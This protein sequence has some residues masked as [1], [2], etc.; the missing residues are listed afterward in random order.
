M[1]KVKTYEE[2]IRIIL[3]NRLE[4]NCNYNIEKRNVIVWLLCEC[5]CG[6]IDVGE[7]CR[8]RNEVDRIADEI[9]RNI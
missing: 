7:Y 8:L 1:K 2:K 4:Q 5:T 6:E 9:M 3:E